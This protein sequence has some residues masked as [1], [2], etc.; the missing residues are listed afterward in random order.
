MPGCSGECGS[1]KAQVQVSGAW[2]RA[3]WI[4][5]GV[6]AAMFAIEVVGGQLAGSVA[7]KADA[8]DFL[9]DAANYAIA[10]LVAG[11]ALVWR[12]RAAL[13]KGVML[14]GFGLWVAWTAVARA[15]EGAA[16]EPATMGA[17]GLL[18]LA[19]N[20]GVAVMLFR[21]R[22]GDANMRSVWIC[23]RNDAIGNVAVMAAAIGVFGTGSLWPDIIVAAI[24]AGLGIWGGAQIMRQ[25]LGELSLPPEELHRA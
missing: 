7:L 22:E 15:L 11:M 12:A 17:I 10:L 18:A 13:L 4:A 5:L 3:L 24:L 19:A 21:F 8:L 16:P 20:V 25:A 23:S 9:G 2:R 6:N 14:L 1:S